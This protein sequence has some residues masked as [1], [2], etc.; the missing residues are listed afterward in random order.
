MTD[1]KGEILLGELNNVR[2]IAVSMGDSYYR[3]DV[4]M[5]LNVNYI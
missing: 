1:D 5:G 2:S 4:N 3:W